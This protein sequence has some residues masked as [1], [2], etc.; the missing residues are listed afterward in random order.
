MSGIII[1]PTPT[2]FNILADH[3][4]L[5]QHHRILFIEDLLTFG[6]EQMNNVNHNGNYDTSVFRSMFFSA[7]IDVAQLS[8]DTFM[9]DLLVMSQNLVES[10]A[11]IGALNKP[12]YVGKVDLNRIHFVDQ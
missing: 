12:L 9:T 5:D 11:N 6:K 7:R 10:L 1:V 2:T 4:D 3:Y 8:N